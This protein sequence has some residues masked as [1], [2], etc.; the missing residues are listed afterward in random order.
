MAYC[1]LATAI[2][3]VVSISALHQREYE[4]TEGLTVTWNDNDRFSITQHL[5]D[6][7]D[8]RSSD[9]HAFCRV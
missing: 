4:K 8:V 1:A 9:A 2:P 7:L 5:D 6:L 3:I